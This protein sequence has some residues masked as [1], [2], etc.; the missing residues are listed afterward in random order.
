MFANLQVLNANGELEPMRSAMTMRQLMS[1]TAGFAYV[2]TTATPVDQMYRDQRVLERSSNLQE[3]IAKLAKLPLAYQPGTHWHYS[4]SVDIQGYLVEKLSGQRFDDFLRTRLFVPLGMTDTDFAVAAAKLPRLVT[5]HTRNEQGALQPAPEILNAAATIRP[6]LL[7]GGGGLFSTATDYYRFCQMLLN[8]GELNGVRILK[9]ETVA[10]MH[11]N[12]LPE[13]VGIGGG[14]GGT[15]PGQQFGLDFAIFTGAGAAG[16]D[17][18]QP[19]GTYWWGGAF[20][21]WFWIDP[22]NEIVMVGMIQYR[23]R[24]NF[25][26]T[27]PSA[28]NAAAQA[29]GRVDVRQQSAELVY[30]ALAPE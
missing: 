22:T 28:T 6:G 4:V 29:A 16:A 3:M 5:V 15:F 18:A 11:S 13:G 7:S 20:G 26:R 10:L 17:R 9:P 19:K 1:H 23:A 24:P 12:Q 25:T 14:T 2:L 30:S 8:N 27:T 21:T